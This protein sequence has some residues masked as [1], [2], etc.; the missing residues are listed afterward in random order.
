MRAHAAAVLTIGALA[1]ATPAA[2]GAPSSGLYGLVM[3][4]PTQPVCKVGTPCSAPAARVTLV[5]LRSGAPVSRV[6]TNAAGRYR[7]A[8]APGSYTV[9]A[10]PKGVGRGVRPATVRVRAGTFARRD[11]F[12]DT[13]I[14]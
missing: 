3:R 4:G 8:L 1:G 10:G 13:G 9:Q 14:R 12:V 7:I 2:V 11:F 6:R 5:F